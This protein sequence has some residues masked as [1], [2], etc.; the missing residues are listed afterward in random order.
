MTKLDYERAK[1]RPVYEQEINDDA[2]TA[3]VARARGPKKGR[4]AGP[5]RT[6]DRGV[7]S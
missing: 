2:M 4:S 5:G 3:I 1:R 6:S 7:A